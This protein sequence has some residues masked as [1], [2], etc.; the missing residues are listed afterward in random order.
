MGDHCLLW[1]KSRELGLNSQASDGASVDE[2]CYS[3]ANHAMFAET[4]RAHVH[5]G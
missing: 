3:S 2:R 1:L 5:M 4:N